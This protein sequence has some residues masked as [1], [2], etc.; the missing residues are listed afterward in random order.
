MIDR[1]HV[2]GDDGTYWHGDRDNRKY[3]DL[4]KEGVHG[5]PQ[6]STL[7]LVITGSAA[8]A[9]CRVLLFSWLLTA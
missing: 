5:H 8:A 4:V 6:P 7:V 9:M 1:S 2:E 3:G